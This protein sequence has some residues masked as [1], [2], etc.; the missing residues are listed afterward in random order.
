MSLIGSETFKWED[1]DKRQ[2]IMYRL[3][4][5]IKFNDNIVVRED[6]IAVFF[7]D[8]KVLAYIDR[9][10]RYALTSLNA[11]IV[12][13]DKGLFSSD[14]AWQVK[15]KLTYTYT[16]AGGRETKPTEKI[17]SFSIFKSKDSSGN[18]VWKAASGPK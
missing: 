4:R 16:M 7:R 6:E 17:Q 15:V 10:D 11:P 12:V 1:A 18:T 8:G 5:N 13:L 14:G 3:P 2:N 9:A